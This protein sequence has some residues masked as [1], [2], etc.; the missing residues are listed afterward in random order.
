MAWCGFDEKMR[1]GILEYAAGVARAIREKARARGVLPAAQLEQERSEL[2][3]LEGII[4]QRIDDASDCAETIS[5]LR[6]FC[7]LVA[8]A[9]FVIDR[10]P[11][12]L[13]DS[14]CQKSAYGLASLIEL[15]DINYESMPPDRGHPCNAAASLAA[16]I[17][18]D[19]PSNGS[20]RRNELAF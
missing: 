8:I 15:F 16:T 13:S 9:R 19:A 4:Q 6:A 17:P 2:E 5:T 7:G 18:L 10:E 11:T 1:S 3:T 20:D 14:T 12:A